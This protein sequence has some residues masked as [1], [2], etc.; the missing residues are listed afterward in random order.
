MSTLRTVTKR[1]DKLL[2][3]TSLGGFRE[4]MSLEQPLLRRSDYR[5]I[6]LFSE[7]FFFHLAC[8]LP[9]FLFEGTTQ[10]T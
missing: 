3:L 4:I 6:D 5:F 8:Y 10:M 1:N 9:G 2:G 7:I